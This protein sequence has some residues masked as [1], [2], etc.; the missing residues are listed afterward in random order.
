MVV[1]LLILIFGTLPL[2]PSFH[3]GTDAM[4]Q[5]HDGVIHAVRLLHLER[6]FWQGNFAPTWIPTLAGGAGSAVFL[7]NWFVPYYLALL[8]KL[9]G[10]TYVDSIK[11]VIL[12]A[13]IFSGVTMYLLGTR[14]TNKNGGLVASAF[15]LLS[16]HRLNIIFTRCAVGE[17]VGQALLPL[18]I[19]LTLD[20]TKF[21]HAVLF[22]GILALS[23]NVTFIFATALILLINWRVA[24]FGALVSAFF[25]LPAMIEQK[26]LQ[27]N[28]LVSYRFRDQFV[29]FMALLNSP[30]QYGPP[31]PENQS[32]SM[33]F[34]L[35]KLHWIFTIIAGV[36]FYKTRN[37]FLGLTI[38]IFIFSI[39][40]ALPI[41]RWF[42][43]NIPL[44]WVAVFPWRFQLVSAPGMAVL[45]GFVG[46]HFKINKIFVVLILALLVLFNRNHFWAPL[47]DYAGKAYLE[48]IKT[49]G[50]SWGEFLPKN[51]DNFPG[52]V[53]VGQGYSY[54]ET[55]IRK[56][57]KIF[58]GIGIIGLWLF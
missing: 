1:L 24:V 3:F 4:Y 33:S 50:G 56:I 28:N 58:S 10:T 46:W 2:L 42:W 12:F 49:D 51:Y 17:V 40:V 6:A 44:L 13:H 5:C 55:P 37:K 45:A 43:E 11:L 38:L 39:L 23:H 14:L 27:F 19:Y 7:F 22:L 32:L 35:G 52:L 26:Y 8:F 30:W 21:R 9:F 31:I 57:A 48:T 25:W 47:G 16:P 54:E 29:P 41:S 18:V 36:V 15:Y 34:Q 53:K 20:K